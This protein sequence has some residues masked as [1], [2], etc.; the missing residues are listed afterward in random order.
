MYKSISRGVV[1]LAMICI[2]LAPTV[3]WAQQAPDRLAT[4]RKGAKIARRSRLSLN[5]CAFACVQFAGP[6]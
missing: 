2:L 5:L 4:S 3:S 1:A 6:E